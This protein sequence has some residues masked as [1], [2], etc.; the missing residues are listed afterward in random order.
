MDNFQRK[1]ARDYARDYASGD[2]SPVDA[3]ER[4]LEAVDDTR[5]DTPSL[6]AFLALR[7]KDVRRQA[8][9]SAERLESGEARSV[10]EGVP[11][12]IKDAIDVEGYHTTAGTTFQGVRLAEAD[13]A[14]I[15]RLR[16]A[17]AII[18]GKTSLHEIGLGGTGVNPNQ[19]T[20]RNP[21]DLGRMTGGSSSGSA[22]AVGAGIC[23]IALG[24]DAGGSIRIPAAMCGVYG[25]KP[26]FGRVP[27]TGGA[28]LAWSLDHFG[29][30][31]ASVQDLAD[32]YDATAGEHPYEEHTT[33]QPPV[34]PVGEIQPANLEDLRVAW[35]PTLA[36]DASSPVAHQFFE[37]LGRIGDAGAI[38]QEKHT[39][40]LRL[41]QKAGYVTMASEAAA[42]QRDWLPEHRHQLNLDTRLLLAVGKRVTADEYLHAQRVREL[43][44]DEFSTL[45]ERFD[46]FVT[47]TAAC[48]APPLTEAALSE[49]EVN[50]KVNSQVSRYTFLANVTGY[51]AVT[52]PAGTDQHGLPVGLML[53]GPAWKE[54]ELLEV[55]AAIDT[56]MPDLQAPRIFYDV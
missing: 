47:P 33:G 26:T 24:S 2:D 39:E 17:G 40:L 8:E 29:P 55:A 30:L 48:T 35:C 42:T 51:P 10:L 36:E 32:F 37:A 45:L 4:A 6:G 50:S 56:L 23:P 52:L 1:T 43:V 31:G 7:R 18:F 5:A 3:I 20:A 54:R 14:L 41:A 16:R 34:A 38:V 9:D 21:Y 25:L 19:K 15:R 53:H 28:L 13:G 49:G 27:R 46:V 22:A 12:A 44:R 11:V